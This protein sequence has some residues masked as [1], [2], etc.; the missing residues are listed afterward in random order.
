MNSELTTWNDHDLDSSIT[1]NLR[2]LSEPTVR[3]EADEVIRWADVALVI[4]S[5]K[6]HSDDPYITLA[7]K[8]NLTRGARNKRQSK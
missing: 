7:I 6:S 8:S 5:V 4:D 1:S 3:I 2:N